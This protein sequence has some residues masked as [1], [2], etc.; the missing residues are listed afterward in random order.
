MESSFPGKK[1]LMLGTGFSTLE[2]SLLN[3]KKEVG[4]I[5]EAKSP[6]KR[7]LI[8]KTGFSNSNKEFGR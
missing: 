1:K 2:S 3:S 7:K 5:Y 4:M 6:G 8:L